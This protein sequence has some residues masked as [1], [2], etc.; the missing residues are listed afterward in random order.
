TD[1]EAAARMREDQLDILFELGGTT[2]HNR[3]TV[4]TWRPAPVQV[5]WLGYPH[6]AGLAEV[7]YILVDPYVKPEDSKL[8]IERPFLMPESW[9]CLD[10]LGFD[11]NWLGIWPGLPEER[12]GCLPFGTAN[13][14]L[15]YSAELVA[16]WAKTMLQVP[17]SRFLFVRPEGG[18]AAFRKNIGD[19]FE[20]H[21]V[22]AGRLDFE[23]VRGNHMP[24][25][26]RIDIALD[27]C[28]QTGGTTTCQSLWMGVPTVTL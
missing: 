3:L 2:G 28:P 7:D 24:H 13:N 22:S 4:M 8:L 27:T 10:R 26:N 23:P 5:S 25:Y 6:S 14:P 19:A 17:C 21:G 15:K 16:L 18:S 12:A 1:E 9:V 20:R 11:D